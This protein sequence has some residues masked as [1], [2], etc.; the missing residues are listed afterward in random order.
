MVQDQCQDYE[1]GYNVLQTCAVD[2]E[3][4]YTNS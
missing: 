3:V 1:A 4:M 2:V